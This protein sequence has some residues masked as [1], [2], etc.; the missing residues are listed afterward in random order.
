MG[1]NRM[2]CSII[3]IALAS[4]QPIAAR[5][6]AGPFPAWVSKLIA[7]QRPE[8]KLV[9][10]ER[11]YQGHRVFE[12]MPLDRADDSGNE[13]VLHAEDGHVICEFGGIAG[14]VT[15]GSCN[16]NKISFVRTIFPQHT[17]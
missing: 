7:A 12:V 14:H 5:E 9:I 4:Y 10:E 6:I 17:H 8:S 16:I 2:A 15:K 1:R 13:H 3:I 11:R